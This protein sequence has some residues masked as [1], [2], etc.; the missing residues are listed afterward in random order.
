[1]AGVPWVF[2]AGIPPPGL[3]WVT[4]FGDKGLWLI[5][6]YL[7]SSARLMLAQIL[8]NSWS[9]SRGGHEGA[10]RL[11]SQAE[12]AGGVQLDKKGSR[13]PGQSL[14]GLQ[15]SCRGA[16]DKGW[17]DRTQ[18]MAPTNLSLNWERDGSGDRNEGGNGD[19]K[20]N[21]DGNWSEDRDGN[22]DRHKH[23]DEHGEGNGNG[24]RNGD[25]NGDRNGEE[26]KD[27]DGNKNKD[28]NRNK[29][30]D[31]IKD[32]HGN[33]DKDGDRNGDRNKH[34]N[35]CRN[36]DRDGKRTRDGNGNKNRMGIGIDRNMGTEMGMK[37]VT[38]MGMGTRIRMGI[39]MGTG[40][41]LSGG[42]SPFLG[43]RGKERLR[44]KK[45]GDQ[46]EGIQGCGTTATCPGSLENLGAQGPMGL[47]EPKNWGL[48]ELRDTESLE[49]PKS[50][51]LGSS[52][53]WG[54][55][56]PW[57][58]RNPGSSGTWCAW[59]PQNLESGWEW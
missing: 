2:L 35:R 17:R 24:D 29:H 14:K 4:H 23:K 16:G 9:E 33:K 53:T 13:E 5:F 26:N 3:H 57:E 55:W 41:T 10:P 56:K 8:S 45:G 32:K 58:L 40:T 44:E 46:S 50:G 25:E 22:R 39:G 43:G 19:G 49:T 48:C 47:G 7:K 20:R 51:V 1:M 28:G 52:G 27:K 54:A 30:G 21:R 18:G 38:G 15:E 37:M 34:R 42:F 36:W 6:P 12:R 11:W 31:R 59:K